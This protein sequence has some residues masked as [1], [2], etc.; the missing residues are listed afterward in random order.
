MTAAIRVLGMLVLLG[1]S[2]AAPRAGDGRDDALLRALAAVSRPLIIAADLDPLLTAAR[3]ARVV[4][5]GEA[6]HGTHEFQVWRDRLT[7]RLIA[8][9]GFEVVAI[10]GD[11]SSL[12]A[13]DRYVRHLPGAAASARAALAPI[14][15]WPRWVWA[16]AEL[17]AFAEWLHAY[18]RDRPLPR[19]VGIHGIDLYAVWES[20]AA[21]RAFYDRH[22]PA[23][24]SWLR[25]QYALLDGFAGDQ[26]GYADHVRR[27]GRSARQA[28]AAVVADLA[29]RYRAAPPGAR[30]VLF[31]A[32]QHA[33]VVAA[34]ERYLGTLAWPGHLS[35]NIRSGH[36][37]DTLTHLLTHY[38][39][40]SR[41]VVWAH[42]THVGDGRATA[43]QRSGEATLGQL[44]RLRYGADA[45]LL[46]GFATARGTLLA[47]PHWDG[48]RQLMR[49]PRPRADSLDAAL[50]AS[51]GG[52]RVL[53]FDADPAAS[54]LLQ[55]WLPQRAIGVVY[56]PANEATRH[57][58]ATR[59][60]LRYDALV[61]V[62]TTR[63]LE[64]L[65]TE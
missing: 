42:N 22:V 21:V 33:R 24:A 40:A 38:G 51:G 54:R 14:R 55:R 44:A 43:M 18:N 7:R 47:A 34:G 58:V 62:P 19:R 16:N 48:P 17:A 35:W 4:M 20:S 39:P 5:L 60:A 50:L 27:G 53:L 64:P 8:E 56:E 46:V 15:R 9:Q 52:D 1:M 59:P 12:L 36:F 23:L 37:S 2:A 25:R 3:A 45:V 11:W 63:A 32:L 65:P 31:E 30:D 13:L 61:F 26:R 28:A 10:E 49:I 29:A 57:Y 41:A 6:S